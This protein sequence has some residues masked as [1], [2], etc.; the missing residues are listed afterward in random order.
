MSSG[1]SVKEQQAL[2]LC[3]TF[4]S[5][6]YRRIAFLGTPHRTLKHQINNQ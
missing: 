6:V 3:Q 2:T 5:P 1:L 4:S